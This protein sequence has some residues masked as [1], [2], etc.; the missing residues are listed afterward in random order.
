MTAATAIPSQPLH[1]TDG[2]VFAYFVPADRFDQQRADM[3]VLRNQVETLTRQRN[4]YAEQ[5]KQE[6]LAFIPEPPTEDD[7]RN[8]EASSDALSALIAELETK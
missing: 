4:H 6:L 3:E 1:D 8:A 5:L 2:K 7:F